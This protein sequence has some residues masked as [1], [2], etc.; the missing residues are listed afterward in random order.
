L[1]AILT[2]TFEQDFETLTERRAALEADLMEAVSPDV[3]SEILD[4]LL[5]ID[6]ALAPFETIG[7]AKLMQKFGEPL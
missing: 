4:E 1:E 3:R 6:N 2:T 5:E 7:D